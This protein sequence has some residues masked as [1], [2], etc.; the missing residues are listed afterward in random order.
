METPLFSSKQ[1]DLQH[2]LQAS[3]C[4]AVSQQ[5]SLFPSLKKLNF[6]ANRSV[7]SRSVIKNS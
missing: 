4:K 1:A 6:K 5:I 3:P 2:V 7:D